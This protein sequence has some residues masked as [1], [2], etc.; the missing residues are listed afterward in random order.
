MKRSQCSAALCSVARRSLSRPFDSII[1]TIHEIGLGSSLVRDV[2]ISRPLSSATIAT[3]RRERDAPS[4]DHRPSELRQRRPARLACAQACPP[5]CRSHITGSHTPWRRAAAVSVTSSRDCTPRGIAPE[6]SNG[7]SPLKR[8]TDQKE[9]TSQVRLQTCAGEIK[10]ARSCGDGD[11]PIMCTPTSP[12]Q[13]T[14]SASW[15]TNAKEHLTRLCVV[16]RPRQDCSLAVVAFL[17]AWAH[18]RRLSC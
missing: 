16:H 14:A 12:A 11:Q 8:V 9:D 15:A 10:D 5:G 4:D 13:A 6:R 17:G 18:W 7:A 1:V 3:S 2:T